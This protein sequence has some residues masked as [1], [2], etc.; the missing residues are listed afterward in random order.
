MMLKN[1]HVEERE[2]NSRLLLLSKNDEVVSPGFSAGS[3]GWRRR[4]YP[5]V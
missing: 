4:A 1:N 2:V 5:G 3:L